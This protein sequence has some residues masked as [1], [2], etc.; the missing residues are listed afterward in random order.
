MS[1]YYLFDG[2]KEMKRYKILVVL[3]HLGQQIT[4]SIHLRAENENKARYIVEYQLFPYKN[5]EIV[6]VKEI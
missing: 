3:K 2:V 6:E 5:I 4:A 1:K